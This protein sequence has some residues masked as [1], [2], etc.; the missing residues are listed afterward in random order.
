MKKYEIKIWLLCLFLFMLFV[1]GWGYVIGIWH[2]YYQ[3]NLILKVD[4]VNIGK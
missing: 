4:T 1:F 3:E 2:D